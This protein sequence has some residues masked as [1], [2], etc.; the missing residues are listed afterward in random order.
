MNNPAGSATLEVPPTRFDYLPFVQH[1]GEAWT[2]QPATQGRFSA[3]GV[4]LR[5]EITED[6]AW[7]DEVRRFWRLS[8]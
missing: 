8:P 5:P 7:I 2:S 4:W 3:D 6:Q 1:L